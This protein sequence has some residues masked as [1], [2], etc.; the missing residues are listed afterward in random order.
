MGLRPLVKTGPNDGD[1]PGMARFAQLEPIRVLWAEWTKG[2]GTPE[3]LTTWIDRTFHVS[4]LRL[5][6]RAQGRKAM[7]ARATCPPRS[8]RMEGRRS[9]GSPPFDVFVRGAERPS[10][11]HLRFSAPE[12]VLKSR[13]GHTDPFNWY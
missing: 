9:R 3:G 1:R 13:V 6:T 7:E 8:G 5:P 2:D 11:R 12:R 10:E 4:S